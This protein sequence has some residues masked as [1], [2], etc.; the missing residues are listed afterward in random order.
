MS[1]WLVDAGLVFVLACIGGQWIAPGKARWTDVALLAAA[2]LVATAEILACCRRLSDP[3]CWIG[4]HLSALLPASVLHFRRRTQPT[5]HEAEPALTVASS[6]DRL[7]LAERVLLAAVI[8]GYLVL[9]WLCVRVPPNNWDSL[10][11]HL[12]RTG[13]YLQQSHLGHFETPNTRQTDFPFNAELL[14]LWTLVFLRAETCVNLI[15]WGAALA[16][17]ATC[18]ALA[19]QAG[20]E[21]R[22]ALLGGLVFLTLPIVVFEATTTQNDLVATWF[23]LATM[24]SLLRFSQS[25]RTGDALL[26]GIACGLAVG[27]KNTVLLCLPG[28]FLAG[29]L[30]WMCR[31]PISGK[32]LL[33]GVVP[34]GLAALFLGGSWCLLNYSARGTVFCGVEY[35]SQ[36]VAAPGLQSFACN[37][38]R[39]AYQWC[40]WT[41]LPDRNLWLDRVALGQQS[42]ARDIFRNQ[43]DVVNDDRWTLGGLKHWPTVPYAMTED[44]AWFGPNG[45]LFLLV[46]GLTGLAV[47]L[48]Q[49]DWKVVA[50]ALPGLSFVLAD[51]LLLKWQPW[52]GR[53]FCIAAGFSVPVAA[54]G[55]QWLDE[56]S[57]GFRISLL[58]LLCGLLT[59]YTCV[60]HNSAKRIDKLGRMTEAE[61]RFPERPQMQAVHRWLQENRSPGAVT[62]FFGNGDDADYIC[63]LPDFSCPVRHYRNDAGQLLEQLE[64]GELEIAVA[65]FATKDL[66][67][68]IPATYRVTRITEDWVGLCRAS[69]P[70]SE[71]AIEHSS[72]RGDS[73]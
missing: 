28:L 52:G 29:C 6:G 2:I 18:V 50:I 39:Y 62:G 40:D 11:Y 43:L 54:R 19:Q 16:G 35:A 47:A 72:G 41:G 8:L 36:R 7:G 21:R 53:L 33:K 68:G 61:L 27:T 24:L 66:P 65:H 59:L 70:G 56:H 9:A 14:C 55:I 26:A 15:Q 49:R 13:Y 48:R 71:P 4:L 30:L 17:A 57:R 25:G 42:L 63:F 12:S 51:C 44:H 46:G 45:V 20:V 1:G 3:A 32:H 38:L 58:V 69:S 5:A 73:E 10:T 60:T 22:F 64:R 31:S 67:T 23:A 37:A 34:A